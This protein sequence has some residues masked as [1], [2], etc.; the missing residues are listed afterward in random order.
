[1]AWKSFRS[2]SVTSVPASRAPWA[3]MATSFLLKDSLRVL[4]VKA[5]MRGIIVLAPS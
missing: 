5:R 2:M 3:A 1:M 4:L